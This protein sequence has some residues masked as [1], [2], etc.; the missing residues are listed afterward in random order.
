MDV[1]LLASYCSTNERCSYESMLGTM[2]RFGKE[3]TR[4]FQIVEEVS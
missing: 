2:N 3:S 1:V 4:P